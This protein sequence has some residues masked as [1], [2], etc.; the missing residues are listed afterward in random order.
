MNNTIK[1]TVLF[2]CFVFP[3]AIQ[4]STV[5]KVEFD[6]VVTASEFVF[7]GEVTTKTVRQ[8]SNGSA[9]TFFTFQIEEVIKGNYDESMIEL[10]FLGGA[11][12]DEMTLI[13]GLVMPKVG[14]RGIYFVEKLNQLFVNPLYGWH[15]GHYL[16]EEDTARN[17]G[18]RRIESE[19][20]YDRVSGYSKSGNTGSQAQQARALTSQL[21]SVKDFKQRIHRILTPSVI[22]V[23]KK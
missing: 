8:L 23:Q 4:S 7:Q 17:E 6:E 10:G 15:Q 16:I 14:E 11:I 12:G 21:E 18:V 20:E 19:A 22:P 3:W 1:I 2:L 5:L 13:S 9:M